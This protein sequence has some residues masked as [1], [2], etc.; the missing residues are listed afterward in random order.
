MDIVCVSRKNL[1]VIPI[2]CIFFRFSFFNFKTLYKNKTF[3]R[4]N[5][6]FSDSQPLM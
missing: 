4:L 2:T 6:D 5:F 3:E 1:L